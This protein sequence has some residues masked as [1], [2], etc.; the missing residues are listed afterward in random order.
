[1][2][3]STDPEAF[4]LGVAQMDRPSNAQATFLRRHLE[5]PV[6][7]PGEFTNADQTS[8]APHR[9]LLISLSHGA[10]WKALISTYIGT[11]PVNGDVVSAAEHSM[12]GMPPSQICVST[13]MMA[14]VG[15]AASGSRSMPRL[16][17][18][19]PFRLNRNGGSISLF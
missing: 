18:P 17:E 14:K 10:E 16:I 12:S 2:Q 7:L 13:A 3:S 8:Q 19:F 5:T 1:M 11:I 6:R 9:P 4:G 15:A